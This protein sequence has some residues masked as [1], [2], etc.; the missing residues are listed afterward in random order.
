[1]GDGERRAGP[2]RLP[3]AQDP[4]SPQLPGSHDPRSTH[5]PQLDEYEGHR[6]LMVDGVI[7]SVAV[8]EA[9]PPFGYW[10]A[11]L[12]QGSPRTALLLGLG[13]G[14]L[15][16]LLTRQ[17]P[18]VRITGVDIDPGIIEF[19][20]RHFDLALPNLE[21]IVADAFV[22]VSACTEQF[23]YVA[24]DLFQGAAFHRG[25]LAR[26]FLRRLAAIA[27][28]DGDIVINMYQDHRSEGYLRRIARV[29]EVV[30]AERLP[31]NVLAHCRRRARA[32]GS[33][34]SEPR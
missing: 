23:D 31:S 14:T 7:F 8:G 10:A 20:R 32:A 13:A 19:A 1:V 26:P 25:V 29:L 27:G 16:H 28:P 30:R 9:T 34:P 17:S 18:A 24:V 6:A 5:A 3:G 4:E 2:D 12:P 33:Q 15:A 11:M 21:V 22:Y